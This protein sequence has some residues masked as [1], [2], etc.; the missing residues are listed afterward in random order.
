MYIVIAYDVVDDRR[1]NRVFKTLKNHGQH[2]QYSVFECELKRRDFTRL[3]DRLEQTINPAED[4][5]RFYFLDLDA[6]NR[7]EEMGKSRLPA[8]IRL[9]RF[10]IF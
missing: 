5:V 7:I 6:V 1:R 8:H 3:R 4:N 9:S 10:L 2:V